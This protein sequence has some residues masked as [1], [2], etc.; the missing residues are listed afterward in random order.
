MDGYLTAE[1][2][3]QRLGIKRASVHRY[4]YRGDIPEP[5]EYAGR[6]P[7]WATASIDTWEKT[8]PGQGWRRRRTRQRR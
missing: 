5:D 2:L 1:Q 7:L 4:R 3:A 8:R 6:T